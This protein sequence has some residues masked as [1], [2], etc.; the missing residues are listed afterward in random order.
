MMALNAL[1]PNLNEI[2]PTFTMLDILVM[3]VNI[4]QTLVDLLLTFCAQKII[5]K[6]GRFYYKHFSSLLIMKNLTIKLRAILKY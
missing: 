2:L 5:S 6:K 3:F 1:F 4:K